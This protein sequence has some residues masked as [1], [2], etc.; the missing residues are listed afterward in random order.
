MKIYIT[1]KLPS[2]V[3]CRIEKSGLQLTY[4]DSDILPERSEFI[5]NCQEVDLLLNVGMAQLDADFM[6]ACSNLKGIALA[7]VGYDHVDL[8]AAAKYGISVSN[9]P[10]V[11]SKTTAETAFLLMLAT[12]R[13]AFFRA[14]EV[15]KGKWKG[16]GFL[17]ELGVEI[18]GKTL[19]IF[20][21]GRIG[22][23]MARMSKAAFGMDILYHN[24]NRNLKAEEEIGAIYVSYEELLERSDVLSVHTNLSPET[25]YK[26]DEDSFS[27]MKPNSIFINTS[28]GKVHRESDLIKALKSGEIW[29]AGLDVTDPE[30]MRADNPLLQMPNVCVLPHIGSATIETRT[31]MAQMAADNLLAIYRGEKMPQEIRL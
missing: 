8:E 20:G 19:G 26:F 22:I 25:M 9:T 2:D 29:G 10:G 13:K 12:A 11:L 31:A 4:N 5:R 16:F 6:Q 30:P 18:G 3:L 28:R 14:E 21:L 1:R 27:R 7:S 17:H 24:R 15:K 23:Q